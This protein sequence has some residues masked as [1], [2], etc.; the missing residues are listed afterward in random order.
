MPPQG[1]ARLRS[2]PAEVAA[3]LPFRP[4]L[5][6]MGLGGGSNG[7]RVTCG[8]RCRAAAVGAGRA[9]G[10][11]EPLGVIVAEAGGES[12]HDP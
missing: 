7:L 8:P 3:A 5:G 12:L 10:C 1:R 9:R 2:P 11:S 6:V 4:S